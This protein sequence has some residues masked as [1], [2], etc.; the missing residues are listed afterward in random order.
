MCTHIRAHTH[1]HAQREREGKDEVGGER[2]RLLFLILGNSF[3]HIY[4][5][6]SANRLILY[7]LY[8]EKCSLYPYIFWYFYHGEMLEFAKSC[9]CIY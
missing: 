7:S 8:V 9:F 2:E 1:I 5:I 4:Y 3:L 6:M